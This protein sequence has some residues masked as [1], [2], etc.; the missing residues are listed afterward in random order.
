MDNA[1]DLPYPDDVVMRMLVTLFGPGTTI[2][3]VFVITHWL[4]S[5]YGTARSTVRFGAASIRIAGIASGRLIRM[6]PITAAFALLTSI[7][8]LLLQGLWLWTCYV[9]GNAWSYV[10]HGP[11]PDSGPE[12]NTVLQTLQWNTI[13]KIYFVASIAA[14]ILSYVTVKKDG[15]SE[16]IAS[17]LGAPAILLGLFTALGSVLTLLFVLLQ[18]VVTQHVELDAYGKGALVTTGLILV[19]LLSCFTALSTPRLMV[20]AWTQS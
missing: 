17:I 4:W 10:V 6:P 12:W 11:Y 2:I 15:S 9:V 20:R 8:M 16:V 19:Y 1:I 14:L 13:S 5:W 18:L 3:L 7:L